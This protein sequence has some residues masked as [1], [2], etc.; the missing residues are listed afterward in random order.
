MRR[1]I[2]WSMVDVVRGPGALPQ[3]PCERQQEDTHTNTLHLLMGRSAVFVR[4]C[5]QQRRVFF[6]NFHQP[7]IKRQVKRESVCHCRKNDSICWSL[8]AK[9][10]I[11]L[12]LPQF[13]LKIGAAMLLG[14]L[15]AGDYQVWVWSQTSC[16]LSRSWKQHADIPP[17]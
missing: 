16:A 2:C 12:N 14:N 17:P 6:P 15:A 7:R 5:V 10:L 4:L 1:D 9:T 8:C 13:R 11:S 3:L